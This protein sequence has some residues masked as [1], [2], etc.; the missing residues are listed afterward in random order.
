MI[1]GNPVRPLLQA[2]LLRRRRE[3]SRLLE[4]PAGAAARDPL[5][6]TAPNIDPEETLRRLMEVFRPV[7]VRAPLDGTA[8][9][10]FLSQVVLLEAPARGAD[11]RFLDAWNH[12]YEA[13]ASW[14]APLREEGAAR[15]TL[16]RYASILDQ[17]LAEMAGAA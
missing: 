2:A 8:R 13:I 3:L 5:P 9:D 17:H 6:N 15:F 1:G 10:V 14:P 16:E 12:A 7:V 4:E 11:P